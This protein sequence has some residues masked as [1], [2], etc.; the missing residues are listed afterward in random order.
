MKTPSLHYLFTKSLRL[1]QIPSEWKLANI[2]PLHK[3]GVKEH[4]ENYRPISLLSIVSK[5]LERCVLNHLYLRIQESVHSA[6]YGFISGRSTTSQLLSTLHKIG[7]DLDKGLQTDVV[8]MDISK[9]FDT[10]DHSKL[11]IWLSFVV[12]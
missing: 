8:F 9:A 1:S 2:I 6:Q 5:T 7:K 11:S 12:V 4:V 3:K 10:V